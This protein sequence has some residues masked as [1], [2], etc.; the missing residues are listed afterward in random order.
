MGYKDTFEKIMVCSL[1]VIT[2]FM[3]VYMVYKINEIRETTNKDYRG[4][5]IEFHG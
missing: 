4:R 1:F 2:I 5:V 3:L